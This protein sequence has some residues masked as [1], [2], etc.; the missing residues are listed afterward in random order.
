MK[1]LFVA[2]CLLALGA[3]VTIDSAEA[4]RL[5]GARSFGAQRIAPM[6]RRAQPAPPQ[7]SSTKPAQP[8]PATPATAPANR[9]LGPI[10]A[11]AAGLGLGWLI[12]NG[13]LGSM[14]GSMLLMLVLAFAVI[15]LIRLF[16]RREAASTP[17]AHFAGPGTGSGAEIGN[18]TVAAPP[19]SQIPS[20]EAD[21]QPDFRSQFQARIPAGFDA[22]GFVKQ[23]KLNFVRLQEANDRGN[24]EALREMTTE[25]MFAALKID[26]LERAGRAQQ[27]DLLS[28]SASLLEVVTEG[29]L[30]W[31]SVRFVGSIREAPNA[32]PLDFEEI[33]NLQKPV[34]GKTGWLL[35]GIQQPA[36]A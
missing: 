29:R 14:I 18:E 12:G 11:L 32:G 27:T 8:A 7:Q 9:W 5:G 2:A 34:D 22:E 28:L 36:L 15:S 21:A 19:P 31:A 6:Q 30:H 35:A 3:A 20:T 1:Q 25:E 17:R 16:A 10:A 26:V 4:A 33:W 23:A 13:G 24:V